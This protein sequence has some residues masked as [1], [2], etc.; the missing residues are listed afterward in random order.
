VNKYLHTVASVGFLFTSLN[1]HCKNK[2]P[3]AVL[4]NSENK[5]VGLFRWYY[6][7]SDVSEKYSSLI[8]RVCE[9]VCRTCLLLKQLV[10]ISI[11]VL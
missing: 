5:K 10:H 8:F 11:A 9:W 4:L 3:K 1:I 6:K 2:G 7:F